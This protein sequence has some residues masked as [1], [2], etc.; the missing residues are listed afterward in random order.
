M[1]TPLK[2]ARERAKQSQAEVAK[3]VGIDQGNYCRIE[4]GQQVPSPEMARRISAHFGGRI[5]P[6]EIIDPKY[7][8]GE[9]NGESD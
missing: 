6:M 7:Y 1:N 2:V 4:N 3:A 5:E 9:P 8:V